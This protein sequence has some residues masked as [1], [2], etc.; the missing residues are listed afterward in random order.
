MKKES[1]KKVL[2]IINI[3]Q[4]KEIIEVVVY[5]PPVGKAQTIPLAEFDKIFLTKSLVEVQYII[6][7]IM[8][9]QL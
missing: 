9:F 5:N 3:T 4:N 1:K 6:T 2:G 8:Q 7:L